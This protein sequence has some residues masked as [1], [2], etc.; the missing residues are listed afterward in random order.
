[1]PHNQFT[2]RRNRNTSTFREYDGCIVARFDEGPADRMI[3]DGKKHSL[4]ILFLGDIGADWIL[5]KLD[6]CNHASSSHGNPIA[7]R[8]TDDDLVPKFCRLC[9]SKA[10][11]SSLPFQLGPPQTP[12]KE[13]RRPGPLPDLDLEYRSW[14]EF[15][16]EWS[17]AG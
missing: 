14:S 9:P 2:I 17:R 12:Q 6:Q 5:C 8:T 16:E 15:G 4:S 7:R 10:S 3:A 11:L 13:V 1:M